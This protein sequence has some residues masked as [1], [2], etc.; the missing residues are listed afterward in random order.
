MNTLDVNP[1]S[2]HELLASIRSRV[3]AQLPRKG[4]IARRSQASGTTAGITLERWCDVHE[5]LPYDDDEFIQA[6]YH[7]LFG[8]EPDAA[9]REYYL[10]CIRDHRCSKVD[11]LR[12]LADSEEG[13]SQNV[14]LIGIMSGFEEPANDEIKDAATFVR[15]ICQRYLGKVPDTPS[16]QRWTALL[17][18]GTITREDLAI[19]LSR[20]SRKRER[21]SL[22]ALPSDVQQMS[23]LILDMR[24]Q[25]AYQQ[26]VI[27][28][29]LSRHV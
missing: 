4:L 14:R 21:P 1:P 15:A 13:R 19:L 2:L 17:D 29:L 26:R 3:E 24:K 12:D 23:S 28:S 27:D 7:R 8:R 6:A 11:V 22:A 10:R 5:I 25:L 16:V 20:T 18:R 9:G